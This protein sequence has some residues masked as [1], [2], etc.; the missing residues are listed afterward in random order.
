MGSPKTLLESWASEGIRLGLE[1]PRKLLAALGNPQER[2]RVVLITGTDGKGSTAAILA[3]ILRAAGRSVGRF[4]SPELERVEEQISIGE[5]LTPKTPLPEG[6]GAFR[7]ISPEDLVALL[8]RI[9]TAAHD[10]LGGPPTPFEALTAAA[11]LHFAQRGVDWAVV[12]AGM[13]GARD[14]TN[15][16]DPELAIV[17]SVSLEH[18]RFL[19]DTLEEIAREKAGGFRPGKPAVAFEALPALVEVAESVGA[20]LHGVDRDTSFRAT[21]DATDPFRGQRVELETPVRRYDLFLPLAGEHQARNLALA[22][23]AVE[24]LELASPGEIASGVAATSWPGRLEAVDFPEGPRVVLDAAHDPAA[25][26]ALVR[27]LDGLATPW[28]LLFGVLQDKE[29]ERMLP[30]LARRAERVVL[31]RPPGPRGR[32]P[33]ELVDLLRGG[34]TPEVIPDPARALEVLLQGPREGL[35]VVTGSVVLVGWV[36]KASVE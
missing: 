25:V 11:Y 19:G 33:G 16:A 14:A 30:P 23:R 7:P 34:P 13:G 9:E 10:A 22:V 29:A 26:Q 17:T 20:T 28:D 5:A 15:V 3:A 18:R 35:R 36:R 31:T 12:E 6:E 8:E 4:T 1:R 27:F 2:F 32:D 24:I 21:P